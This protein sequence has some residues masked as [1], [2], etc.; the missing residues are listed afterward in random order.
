M[1]TYTLSPQIQAIQDRIAPLQQ[2]I[3]KHSVITQITTPSALSMLMSQHAFI[4][5]DFVCLLKALSS[6]ILCTS[7]PWF[8]ARD[9]DSARLVYDLLMSEETDETPALLYDINTESTEKREHASH[10]ELYLA[11]M[12]E[13]GANTKPIHDALAFLKTGKSLKFALQQPD[14]LEVTRNFVLQTFATFE[15]STQ[16]LAASFTFGREAMLPDFFKAWLDQLRVQKMPNCRLLVYY[17]ERHIHLD[18]S[19]HF[20]K[21]ARM[22]DNLCGSDSLAWKQV[23][24]EAERAL[25]ARLAFLT[26]MTEV[27]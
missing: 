10:F 5:W 13:V 3:S 26:G 27:L 8:P 19:D 11:A 9:P 17:L 2:A 24:C 1:M 16:T 18:S 25:K 6:R 12:Q 4:V 7:T 22:L 21:A 15:K 14:I 20:P 23:T